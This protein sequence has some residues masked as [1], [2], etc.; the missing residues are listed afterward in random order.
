MKSSAGNGSPEL[1]IFT[2]ESPAALEFPSED[3]T[4]CPISSD[5]MIR[6]KKKKRGDACHGHASLFLIITFFLLVHEAK[7]LRGESSR[8]EV[9]GK[10]KRSPEVD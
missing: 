5:A 3:F 2:A 10:L 7:N 9:L 6:R 1:Q 8:F 4:T